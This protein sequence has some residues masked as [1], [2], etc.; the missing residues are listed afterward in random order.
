M[1]KN[2]VFELFEQADDELLSALSQS[3]EPLDSDADKRIFARI[4]E[5]CRVSFAAPDEGY[6]DVVEGVD[7]SFW[8]IFFVSFSV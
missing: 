3:C 1:I 7:P 6:E 2:D 8:M 4:Q 5:K